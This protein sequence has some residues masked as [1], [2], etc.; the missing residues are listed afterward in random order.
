LSTLEQA[1]C[2]FAVD[3]NTGKLTQSDYFEPY[4]YDG[5][6]GGDRDFGSSGLAL[7]DPTVFYGT[8]ANAAVTQIAIAGGKDG[9]LYV[10]D[11]N[12]LGGFAGGNAGADH[13]LQTINPSG[14]SFLSG[15]GS[16]PLEGGY[17]YFNPA[18]DSLYAYKFS[19]DGNGK[20]VF[21]K[22]GATAKTYVGKSAPTVTS[23]NGQ[24]G[25]GIV[26]DSMRLL[27]LFV[28][29]LNRSGSQMLMS[30]WW[31][32]MQSQSMVS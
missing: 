12:N 4:G 29:T 22:A 9:T 17:I 30:A 15:P 26:S 21:T 16:Y 25:S 6:N 28:L 19:R 1:A 8:G 31:H 23:N 18:G 20:P 24:A 14:L 27:E 3:P 13:V 10:L 11:A 32:S 5:N 2:N 7:L